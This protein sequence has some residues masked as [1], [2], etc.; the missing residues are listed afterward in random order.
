MIKEKC[1]VRI[2]YDIYLKINLKYLFQFF[3]KKGSTG[4]NLCGNSNIHTYPPTRMY[5]KGL[6]SAKTNLEK[7]DVTIMKH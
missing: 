2:I 6:K 7:Y 5:I 4:L 1:Q 3:P